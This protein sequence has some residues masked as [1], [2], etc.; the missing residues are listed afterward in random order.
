MSIANL[1]WIGFCTV[2]A[3]GGVGFVLWVVRHSGADRGHDPARVRRLV[4]SAPYHWL[5]N[6]LSKR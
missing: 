1:A 6:V 2:A 3:A 4:A 5:D